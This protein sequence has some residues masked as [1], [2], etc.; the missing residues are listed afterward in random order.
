LGI[1]F[2]VDNRRSIDELGIV[3]R[4][5]AQTLHEHYRS[6]LAQRTDAAQ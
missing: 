2:K 1:R 6:W 3:Y 4:P 5:I